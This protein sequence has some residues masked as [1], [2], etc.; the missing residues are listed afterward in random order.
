MH[1]GIYL[2][3]DEVH[4]FCEHTAASLNRDKGVRRGH[5]GEYL[6]DIPEN[7]LIQIVN[8]AFEQ[9]ADVRIHVYQPEPLGYTEKSIKRDPKFEGTTDNNGFFR[10]GANPFGEINNWGTNG[11]LLIQI[12]T[13]DAVAFGWLEI[14]DFNLE[15]WRG[16]RKE[17]I[18]KV[19]ARFE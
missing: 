13:G 2:P 15:Y 18:F 7:N 6:L 3:Q 8:P 19:I 11:V 12:L 4:F 9:L 17:A 14:T 1:T 10:L 16:N 5:F